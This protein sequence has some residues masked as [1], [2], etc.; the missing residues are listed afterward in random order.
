MIA[1]PECLALRPVLLSPN[2]GSRY[3]M[4]HVTKLRNKTDLRRFA[5]LCLDSYFVGHNVE[6][7]TIRPSRRLSTNFHLSFIF[8]ATVNLNTAEL[9]SLRFSSLPLDIIRLLAKCPITSLTLS[10]VFLKQYSDL[11][12]MLQILGRKLSHVRFANLML[13]PVA[14]QGNPIASGQTALSAKPKIQCFMSVLFI[15]RPRPNLGTKHF[16]NGLFMLV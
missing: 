15:A 5:K 9:K 16:G 6:H 11:A 4:F 1:T 8:A 12:T 10:S 2:Y 3:H 7:L 13:F 14:K